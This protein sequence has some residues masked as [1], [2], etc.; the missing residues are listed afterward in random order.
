MSRWL[1]ALLLLGCGP[2]LDSLRGGDIDVMLSDAGPPP[3]APPMQPPSAP[4]A[5]P[6]VEMID[7]VSPVP[8][9][10]LPGLE[11]CSEGLACEVGACLR[12]RCSA[13]SGAVAE[14]SGCGDPCGAR[15]PF[16]AG[17]SCAMGFE[18]S[19]VGE[20]L[21][22]CRDGSPTTLSLGFCDGGY[23]SA[24]VEL[25][26]E[27][28]GCATPHPLTGACMCPAGQLALRF[29]AGRATA[30]CGDSFATLGFCVDPSGRGA[31]QR[32]PL[33]GCVTPNRATGGC[34]CPEGSVEQR[35]PLVRPQGGV[36]VSA[37]V[38]LC[39]EP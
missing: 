31:Y 12:G 5:G 13:S 19:D 8:T 17:C 30:S 32:D 7:P 15:N 10:G 20:L 6:I 1:F 35:L 18:R 9:C 26:P 25:D 14:A 3:S 4:D 27:C 24:F 36:H 22:E 11:C 16:T 23:G 37:P 28:G 21:G 39:L 2:D 38:V 29:R 34:T 33:A